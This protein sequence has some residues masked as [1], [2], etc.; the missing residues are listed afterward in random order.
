MP[1]TPLAEVQARILGRCRPTEVVDLA[2]ARAYGTVAASDVVAAS[3]VRPFASSAMDGYAVRSG[4][5]AGRLTIVGE[6]RAGHAGP[7]V[8]AGEAVVISTGAPVPEGA[9]AVVR[10]EDTRRDGDAVLVDRR[11]EAGADVRPAGDDV[12]AGTRIVAGGTPLN[13]AHLGL[14]ASLGYATVPVHRPPRVGLLA[15]GDELRDL[16]SA[17]ARAADTAPDGRSGRG[18]IPDANRPVLAARI[19]VLGAEPTDL[20]VVADDPDEL[21]GALRDGA[22]TCDLVVTTGAASVGPHDL[23]AEVLG[24]LGSGE[25]LRLALR[26]AKPFVLG[27]V[28]GVPFLGLPGN[29]VAAFVAFELLVRPAIRRLSGWSQPLEPTV[30]AVAS[31]GLPRSE[32]GRLHVVPVALGWRADGRHSARV[33]GPQGSHRLLGLTAADGL[34]LVPDG[35]GVPPG[36]A[37][38]VLPL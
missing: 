26:P 10:L 36:G 34:A 4:D 11:L 23:L 38:D 37:V 17:V 29:P 9:D 7:E 19:R 16:T 2:L 13:A 6:A 24:D 5:T 15:T 21:A 8:G 22:A 3:P 18:V 27:E 35:D 25:A 14:L 32:D 33:S 31:D 12:P 30:P 28:D 20:G 1:L